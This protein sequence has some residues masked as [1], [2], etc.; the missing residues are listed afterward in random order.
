MSEQRA[1]RPPLGHGSHRPS[2]VPGSPPKAPSHR[3]EAERHERYMLIE[4]TWDVAGG[5]QPVILTSRRLL[6]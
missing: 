3:P 4:F 1:A 5:V 2:R 6:H